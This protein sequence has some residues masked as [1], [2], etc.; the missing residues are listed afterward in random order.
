MSADVNE[1]VNEDDGKKNMKRKN[2]VRI[3]RE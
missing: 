3:Y 2:V 1:D